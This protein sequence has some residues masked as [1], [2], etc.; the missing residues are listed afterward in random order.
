MSIVMSAAQ[1]DLKIS[2]GVRVP[3]V[4]GRWSRPWSTHTLMME[5]SARVLQSPIALREVRYR[6][7]RPDPLLD[8]LT[9]ADS[10]I[11]LHCIENLSSLWDSRPSDWPRPWQI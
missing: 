6:S 11:H 1:L 9:I 5:M 3:G 4:P 2:G 10:I 8:E 7:G